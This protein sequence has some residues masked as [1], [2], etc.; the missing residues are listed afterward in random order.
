M[1]KNYRFLVICICM[2]IAGYASLKSGEGINTKKIKNEVDEY[3]SKFSAQSMLGNIKTVNKLST[4][5][6]GE[7]TKYID[8]E[9][10]VCRCSIVVCGEG[11]TSERDYWLVD[12]YGYVSELKEYYSYP[13]YID[14]TR[15]VDILYRTLNEYIIYKDKVYLLEGGY[16]KKTENKLPVSSLEEIDKAME[17]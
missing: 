2:F 5:W 16:F 8:K 9:D 14:Y 17:E 13:I 7:I 10:K 12:K 4:E 6:D 15:P 1:K 3:Y 11:G